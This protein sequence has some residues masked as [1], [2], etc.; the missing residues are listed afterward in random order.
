MTALRKDLPPLPARFKKLPIDPR[1]YPIPWFVGEVNGVRDFRIAD[2]RKRVIG[3]KDELCWLC[4]EKLGR[5]KAFVIGP[6]CLVNRNTSEPGSHL[7]CARFAALACPHLSRPMA[8]SRIGQLIDQGARP[9]A[10]ALEGNPG[11][12]AVY[13]TTHA[14][15]YRVPDTQDWLI[16]LGEPESVEWYCCGR[17]ATRAEIDAVLAERL[18][19]LQKI[20]DAEGPR[21]Q[22][23]LALMVTRAKKWLPEGSHP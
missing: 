4:G 6:M 10:G 13:V 15:A 11:A 12:C 19:L 9:L 5:Y 17:R 18:P 7:E 14:R 2:Q 20:A 16:R 8:K 1:G 22:E 21:A 23:S 3:Y